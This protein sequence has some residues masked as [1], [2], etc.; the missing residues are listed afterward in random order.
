MIRQRKLL[1]E[2]TGMFAHIPNQVFNHSILGFSLRNV[3]L[4][5]YLW[6]MVLKTHVDS[7]LR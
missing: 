6:F 2:M 1:A 3:N 4:A 5:Q 7:Q